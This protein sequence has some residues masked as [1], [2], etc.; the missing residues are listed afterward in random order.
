[1]NI[2]AWKITNNA[3]L[4][5]GYTDIYDFIKGFK[6]H[7]YEYEHRK[8]NKLYF[9]DKWYEKTMRH[10][11][12]YYREMKLPFDMTLK[13]YVCNCAP[14]YLYNFYFNVHKILTS[15][16][17]TLKNIRNMVGKS[18][19]LKLIV[20]NNNKFMCKYLIQYQSL[21]AI[22]D[23]LG[24]K[25]SFGKI[26]KIL[27]VPPGKSITGID[28][29]KSSGIY[30]YIIGFVWQVKYSLQIPDD[31][32]DSDFVCKFGQSADLKNRNNRHIRDFS[33]LTGHDP[34]F[35]CFAEI[36]KEYL[37]TAEDDFKMFTK[38]NKININ[39]HT[40]ELIIVNHKQLQCVIDKYVQIQKHYENYYVL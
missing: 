10:V 21:L 22:L 19:V 5:N 1:M 16:G 4:M 33:K 23:S 14:K 2:P 27:K 24:I 12:F 28:L 9:S 40:T 32:F 3:S 8:L 36:D 15:T 11:K 35:I 38:K 26:Y 7:D 25:N 34:I 30:I 17:L 39:R 13:I 6:V 18:H 29:K 31:Y 20:I 37:R